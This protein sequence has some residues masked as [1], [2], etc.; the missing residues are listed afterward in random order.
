MELKIGCTGWSYAG[1]QGSFYPKNL[2]QKNFLKFYSSIFDITEINSTY[3]KIPNQFIT[4]KWFTDTPQDFVFSAKFPSKITHEHRLK[5]VKSLVDEFLSSLSPL[6][7]KIIALLV[8]LPPSLSFEE[9]KPRIIELLHYLPSYYK[10]PIE[11]R[12]ESWFTDDARDFLEENNLC[13]VWNEVEGVNN[14]ARITSDF[15]YLRLIGD[16][17]IP[18]DQFGKVIQDKTQMIQSWAKKLEKIKE[19]IPLVLALSNNHLEGF[20]PATANT[21][22]TML[23]LAKLEW[24]DKSQTSLSDFEGK[25]LHDLYRHST[26][27]IK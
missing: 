1:W 12:H 23:G 14:P 21:L 18:E 8:Q 24:H 5:N 2:E 6:R 3:Y 27:L 7:K 13:Q 10:F 11:G 4:K 20:A 9:A 17:S 16:R 25:K 19:K 22:R 15:V 26:K